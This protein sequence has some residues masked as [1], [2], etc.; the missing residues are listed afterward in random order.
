MLAEL[1][2]TEE[3]LLDSRSSLAERL[4]LQLRQ[5]LK[6]RDLALKTQLEKRINAIKTQPAI[7]R[8]ASSSRT[9]SGGPELSAASAKRI[10]GAKSQQRESERRSTTA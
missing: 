2:L 6:S 7:K 9:E 1:D 4:R 10:K 5:M 3:Q 8:G